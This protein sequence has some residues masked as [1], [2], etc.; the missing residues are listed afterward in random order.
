MT[1]VTPRE[2]FCWFKDE[3]FGRGAS[4]TDATNPTVGGETFDAVATEFDPYIAKL[5]DKPFSGAMLAKHYAAADWERGNIRSTAVAAVDSFH[6]FTCEFSPNP[7]QHIDEYNTLEELLDAAI[8]K[9][10]GGSQ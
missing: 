5:R 9:A 2:R 6:G 7:A 8:T 4:M 10:T 3:P 1:K